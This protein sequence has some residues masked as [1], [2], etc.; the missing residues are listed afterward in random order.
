MQSQPSQ[1]LRPQTAQEEG[2]SLL[3][4]LVSVAIITVLMA[5]VFQFMNVN[6]QR[7]RSQQLMGEVTQGGRS[8]LEQMRAATGGR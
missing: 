3:E 2:F 4:L 1:R 7:Y 6:Q 5:I 8:V